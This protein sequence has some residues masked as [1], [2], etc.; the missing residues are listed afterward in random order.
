MCLVHMFYGYQQGEA[1]KALAVLRKPSVSPELQV[2][3]SNRYDYYDQTILVVKYAKFDALEIQY[4]V[5]S[6]K[7]VLLRVFQ[8]VELLTRKVIV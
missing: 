6:C 3:F 2:C 8:K 4:H 1:K 5:S 7:R